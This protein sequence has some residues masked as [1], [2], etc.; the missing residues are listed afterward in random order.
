MRIVR[1]QCSNLIQTVLLIDRNLFD[2]LEA[3][4]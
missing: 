2:W 4:V 3:F 1:E